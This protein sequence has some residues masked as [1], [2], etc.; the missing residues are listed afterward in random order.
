MKD[1]RFHLITVYV[2]LCA[3][4]YMFRPTMN[5]FFNHTYNV[6]LVIVSPRKLSK[7]FLEAR[8]MVEVFHPI[9]I[10]SNL[11]KISTGTIDNVSP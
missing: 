9:T 8:K 7:K 3:N 10:Q 6:V 1:Y 4:I 11:S 5:S 2:Q